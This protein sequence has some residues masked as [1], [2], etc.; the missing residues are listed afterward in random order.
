MRSP[1]AAVFEDA[2]SLG[3]WLADSGLVPFIDFEIL[4]VTLDDAAIEIDP[5]GEPDRLLPLLRTFAEAEGFALFPFE[6]DVG[7]LT[8]GKIPAFA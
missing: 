6:E 8:I 3:E 2:E 7:T 1:G 5:I 4:T